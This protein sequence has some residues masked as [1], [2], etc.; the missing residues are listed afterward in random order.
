MNNIESFVYNL[1]R[2]NPGVKQFVR[3]IYQTTFDML[4][5]KKEFTIHPYKYK[6]N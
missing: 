3:N 4:P 5:R 6:E 1:V 2:K